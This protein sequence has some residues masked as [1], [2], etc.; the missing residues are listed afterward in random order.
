[1]RP[2]GSKSISGLS[3]HFAGLRRALK[4]AGIELPIEII[5]DSGLHRN[6]L[7]VGQREVVLQAKLRRPSP[8]VSSKRKSGRRQ[9]CERSGREWRDEQR[10][11]T[12]HD[13]SVL[14]VKPQTRGL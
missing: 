5:E 4:R 6:A 3:R 2:R 9:R 11:L 8:Q 1:M 7:L 14:P 12:R 13:G 10:V